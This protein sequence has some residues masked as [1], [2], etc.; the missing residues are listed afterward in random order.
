MPMP[1][2]LH[3]DFRFSAETHIYTVGGV[4]VPA[5]STIVQHAHRAAGGSSGGPWFTDE[6][7]ERGKAVHAATLA[8]D[9]SSLEYD[10]LLKWLKPAWQPFFFAYFEF[11]KHCRCQWAL[12]EQA[13]VHRALKFAGTPDRVGTLNDWPAILELKTGS[14]APWHGVQTA[15]QDILMGSRG[16]RR[17]VVYLTSDGRYKLREHTDSGDYLKFLSALQAFHDAKENH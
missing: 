7:R 16:R 8:L 17:Y 5:V 4:I 13:R 3:G 14:P 12:M 9:Q 2:Q 10:D 1:A 6:H 15:G 11:R